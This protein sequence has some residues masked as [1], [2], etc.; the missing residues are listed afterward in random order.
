[1]HGALFFIAAAVAN[2][3]EERQSAEDEVFRD[4]VITPDSADLAEYD[5]ID[6]L[7][8]IE[9]EEV[10]A[11]EI[12]GKEESAGYGDES[13]HAVPSRAPQVIDAPFDVVDSVPSTTNSNLPSPSTD[14]EKGGDDRRPDFWH[15]D[16]NTP[17]EATALNTGEASGESRSGFPYYIAAACGAIALGAVLVIAGAKI[18]RSKRS[19]GGGEGVED[20]EEE[21][22]KKE[23]NNITDGNDEEPYNDNAS[24][25]AERGGDTGYDM[26]LL[27]TIGE[28]L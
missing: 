4:V 26:G 11:H 2:G 19:G 25:I 3:A 1:M 15:I 21:E 17:T 28:N 10:A 18:R 7:A 14:N 20:N 9:A 23:E 27:H 6:E 5:R 24:E 22:E 13:D 16:K 12:R 8:A